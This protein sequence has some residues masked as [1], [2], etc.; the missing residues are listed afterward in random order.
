[1]SSETSKFSSAMIL[2]TKDRGLFK[3]TSFA[4][5]SLMWTISYPADHTSQSKQ[6]ARPEHFSVFGVNNQ[7]CVMS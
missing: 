5:F 3:V 4:I 1:M 2:H 6:L 7:N